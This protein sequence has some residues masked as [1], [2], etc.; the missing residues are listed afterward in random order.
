M[1]F[2]IL[3]RVFSAIILFPLLIL[4][5]LKGNLS[6]IIGIALVVLILCW[7]EWIKLF[8]FPLKYFL[9]GGIILLGALIALPF[10][11]FPFVFFFILFFSFLPFLFS[12]ERESFSVNFFPFM[13]GLFYLMLGF[14]PIIMLAE[15][16]PREY[17]VFFFSVVFAT[18]TGAYLVGKVFGRTPF[19]SKISPKKTWEGFLGGVLFAL[20]TSLLLQK[21]FFLW[22]ISI[23]L[24]IGF[25]LAI[26]EAC[27]D[28]FESA[29]KRAVGKKDSGALIPGHGGL[30]DRID[31]VL[32]ASPCFLFSVE[33]F[34]NGI[35][36]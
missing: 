11:A 19:F 2:N 33:V 4:I 15:K 32:F 8:N 16:Y 28:L 9:W 20:L 23:S 22:S 1:N 25:V 27:G 10:L 13:G 21:F 29:V 3:K 17:L 18:D 7:F 31:G 36:N 34:K 6:L 5:V 35:F 30:L 12:F 14:L 24:I 26:T